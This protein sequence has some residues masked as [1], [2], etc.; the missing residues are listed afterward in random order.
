MKKSIQTVVILINI[1]L[2]ILSLALCCCSQQMKSQAIEGQG[3]IG[4]NENSFTL[5]SANQEYHIELPITGTLNLQAKA[6][7]VF[8]GAHLI[9]RPDGVYEI[10]LSA[11]H[12]PTKELSPQDPD[13][14]TVLDLYQLSGGTV[15]KCDQKPATTWK[16][17][18]DLNHKCSLQRQQVIDK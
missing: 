9:K 4:R 2:L 3:A 15:C 14:V 12:R 16:P 13:F 17:T 8:D 11:S 10:Y 6:Q 1:K 5:N 18:E 7:L